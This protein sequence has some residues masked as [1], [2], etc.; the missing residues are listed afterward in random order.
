MSTI[1]EVAR[2]AG[3]SAGTVSRY[4]NGYK[5]K[6]RNAHAIERAI[7]ELGYR[8]NLTAR[9][10]RSSRSMTV[11]LLINNMQNNLAAQV[12]AQVESEMELHDY[13][14]M[15]SGFR[16][17]RSAFERQLQT[18]VAR[19]VDGLILFEVPWSVD[20]GSDPVRAL[21]IPVVALNMPYDSPN[22]DS[23]LPMNRRSSFEVASRMIA[24][25]HER[26]GVIAAPLRE[27]VSRER[28]GGV[29]DAM[30]QAGL[31]SGNAIVTYGDY[32]PGSGRARM[33]E[34]LDAGLDCVFVCN[35][36]MGQG[37]LQAVSERGR[38]IGRDLSYACYDY[39]DTHDFFYPRLT[40]I[41]PPSQELGRVAAS[42]LLEMIAR[43]ER[44]SGR[45]TELP[46]TISWQPS[47]V[48]VRAR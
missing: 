14:I 44:G 30:A 8:P 2:R 31:P 43:G 22:V 46:N 10:L 9:S 12:V 23:I 41:C 36:K 37:A 4:L 3:V 15:L 1:Q 38:A 11:G 48:D 19:G 40:T 17:D 47:I 45:R 24:L 6:Q 42:R 35:F 7:A 16:E 33:G 32:S 34:L 28:L 25:G 21:D 39:A 26:M 20:T 18:L 27:Y 13:T 29:L 5:L